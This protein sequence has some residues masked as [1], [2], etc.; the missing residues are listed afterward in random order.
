MATS[1]SSGQSSDSS[2]LIDEAINAASDTECDFSIDNLPFGIGKIRIHRPVPSSATTATS[3][4][5][6]TAIG[7]SVL[8]LSVLQEAGLFDDIDELDPTVFSKSTLNDFMEHPSDIWS[9]V[10]QRLREI[11]IMPENNTGN[12]NGKSPSVSYDMFLRS[13]EM[14]Q[15]ASIHKLVDVEM[16]LPAQIG[17]YT[18]FYS[19]REHA[20]N[21]GTMFRGKDNALQPN[22]LHLPVGYHGRSS[23]VI[24][25][26]HPIV[27]PCGQTQLDPNDPTK[28][29][30]YGP[31]KL[32]D[33]ELEVAFFVGG[34]PNNLGR[35]LTMAEAK[36]RIFGFCLMNDWS[37]R[38]I[39]KWE[40]VPLG[41]FTSKNFATSISPWVVSIHALEEAF[42]APTSAITQT[43]PVPLE[44]LRDPDYSSYDINLTVAIQPGNHRVEKDSKDI[45]HVV[46]RSN[47]RNLYWNAAQQLV[48]HSVTGC[49]MNPGDLLASGTISGQTNDSF[50]SMLELSWRGSRD[51]TIGETQETRKFLQDGDTVVISGFCAKNGHGRVGFGTCRGKVLSVGSECSTK[52]ASA[53]DRYG[54][55]KLY[56]LWKSSSSWRVRIALE[57]KNAQYEK[58]SV[59]FLAEENKEDWYLKKNPMGQIPVL[60]YTDMFTGETKCIS[61]SVAIIEFLEH[62][63]PKSK[64]LFPT[65]PSERIAATEILEVI[66]SGT[67][68]LQ[69]LA[70][71]SA[72]K[73]MSNDEN[74]VD[75]F[76]KEAIRK[77]LKVV[78]HHIQKRKDENDSAAIGPFAMGGFAPTVVDVYL[79]PQLYNANMAG[80]SVQDEFPILSAIEKTCEK[81]PWFIEAHPSVQ[82]DALH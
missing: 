71:I 56:G 58:I 4:R 25:S 69:N 63:F 30:V 60:E 29:S 1:S 5:C 67:Q 48:H 26:D 21:V 38:D 36:D 8:D 17:D 61:Q 12:E 32:L 23:T 46:C 82:P 44:Y 34:R 74:E 65:D 18:D 16:Q 68:P 53:K 3:A 43:D 75:M 66:N 19:S 55:L 2:R 81:Y 28:G 72:I 14:L 40:Y 51:V 35:P 27:R 64:P 24:V 52:S 70:L 10:R 80:I 9:R 41:P 22:W 39:Q 57:A 42:R 54:Q 13:N 78:E 45:D 62:A 73:K 11:L 76:R 6:L 33:F 59:N 79:I 20:T 7:D 47:F 77:G 15:K 31:C 50:G 49:I 37:A